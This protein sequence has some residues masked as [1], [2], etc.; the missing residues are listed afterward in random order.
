MNRY[1][2]YSLC[3]KTTSSPRNSPLIE[4]SLLVFGA[5]GLREHIQATYGDE[6]TYTPPWELFDRADAEEALRATREALKV[7]RQVVG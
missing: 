6:E 1:G 7:A 5:L 2:R 4:A 3:W